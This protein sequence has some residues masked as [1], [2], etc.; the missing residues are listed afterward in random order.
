MASAHSD[1]ERIVKPALY[2]FVQFKWAPHPA[3]GSTSD[4]KPLQPK[5]QCNRFPALR[6]NLTK[7]AI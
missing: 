1:Q 5:L 2:Q 4:L 3:A 6:K 7:A